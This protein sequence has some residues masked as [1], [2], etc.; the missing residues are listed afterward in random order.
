M[1]A[2]I[3]FGAPLAFLNAGF[4]LLAVGRMVIA[5]IIVVPAIDN[6]GIVPDQYHA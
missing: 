6:A 4:V 1:L 5:I 2:M 3:P